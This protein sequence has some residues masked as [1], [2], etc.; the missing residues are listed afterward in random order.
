MIKTQEKIKEIN[1][2]LII[3]MLK[4]IKLTQNNFTKT[5]HLIS[6]K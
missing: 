6:D 3:I 1:N 2:C 5:G 4:N